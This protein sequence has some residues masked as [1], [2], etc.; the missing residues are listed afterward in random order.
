MARS[1]CFRCVVSDP[2]WAFRDALPGGGRG[3][4]KHYPCMNVGEMQRYHQPIIDERCSS[5]AWLFL[6]RVAAM[7]RQALRLVDLL[8]FEV[9][10]EIV[11]VKTKDPARQRLQIGMGHFVRNCHETCLVCVRGKGAAAL[12]L[13]ASE[14]SVLFAPRGQHSSKPE[15]FY[16]AVE[17]LCPG[18]RLELFARTRRKGWVQVGDE[19]EEGKPG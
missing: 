13:S 1:E 17:R 5:T 16:A 12:R 10:A 6:W 15:A 9:K 2:P 8:G 4:A 19:L 3:A 14:P 18:P 11:W 7:Q